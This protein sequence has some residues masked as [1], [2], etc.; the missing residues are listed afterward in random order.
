MHDNQTANQLSSPSTTSEKLSETSY[1]N[2]MEK[3]SKLQKVINDQ[4]SHIDTL[5]N[6]VY[7]LNL[8][9]D[10]LESDLAITKNVSAV[11]EN[12]VDSL[13]QYCRR[14][15]IVISGI[16]PNPKESNMELKDAVKEAIKDTVDDVDFE[17]DCDKVHRHGPRRFNRHNVIARFRSHQLPADIFS[18]KRRIRNEF[19][20]IK[21]SLTRRRSE[22]LDKANKLVKYSQAGDFCYADINGNLKLR[23][24]NPL[25]G[26]YVYNF[27]T[28]DDLLTLLLEQGTS[29]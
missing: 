17:M 29:G 18:N 27:K 10:V 14:N 6:N 25:N 19:M 23:L 15:C 12:E 4:N 21:P 24:K 28:Y 3:I 26:R 8:R 13:H 20:K 7:T 2:L 5:T 1:G 11:L 9:I 16:P 22:L